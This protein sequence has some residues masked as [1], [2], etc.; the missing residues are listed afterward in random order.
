MPVGRSIRTGLFAALGAATLACSLAL[1]LPLSQP[2]SWKPDQPRL[3]AVSDARALAA[4]AASPPDLDAA[5]LATRETLADRPL[6]AT[7]WA[8]LAWIADQQGDP[9]AMLDALDR[10]YVAAPHGPEVTA[11]RLQFC[12]DRWSDLTPELR[13][14]ARSELIVASRTRPALVRAVKESVS[15]PAGRMALSLTIPDDSSP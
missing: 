10:S 5:A 4:T 7:A 8:R 3:A 1:A 14:Q 13:R 12:L 11:W 15:D 6:D 9:A 2:A